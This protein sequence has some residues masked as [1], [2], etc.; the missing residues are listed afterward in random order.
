MPPTLCSV[1][2]RDDRDATPGL[3][4]LALCFLTL[5]AFQMMAYLRGRGAPLKVSPQTGGS[6]NRTPR[7][8]HY[9]VCL[10]VHDLE[11]LWCPFKPAFA[12]HRVNAFI[13]VPLVNI[14][15]LLMIV[16]GE[17]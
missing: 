10:C 1:D 3:I 6:M 12:R 11:R 9:S 17:V 7:M 15:T 5:L 8:R 2:D 4:R 13:S 16:V 14:L